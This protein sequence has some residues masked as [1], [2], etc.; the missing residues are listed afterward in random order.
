MFEQYIGDGANTFI[1]IVAVLIG[2]ATA[3]GYLDFL[4][5]KKDQGEQ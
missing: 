4:K 2:F 1:I 5:T 3:L